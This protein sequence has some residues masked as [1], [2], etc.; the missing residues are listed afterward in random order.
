V[1]LAFALGIAF[2][3]RGPQAVR[4]AVENNG[5]NAIVVAEMLRSDPSVAVALVD[6]AEASNQLRTGR[7]AAVV[8]PTEPIVLRYD[9]TRDESH[10]ARLVVRD[11]INQVSGR[12]DTAE[13]REQTVTEVGSRYIDFLIRVCSG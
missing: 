1:L 2:K 7:V 12:R 11:A 3:N 4:I 6:A 13:I 5:D 10:L 9:P 8:V